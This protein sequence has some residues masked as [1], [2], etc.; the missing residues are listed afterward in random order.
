MQKGQPVAAPSPIAARGGNFRQINNAPNA[1]PEEHPDPSKLVEEYHQAAIN[2][3]EA[4]FDGV[5]CV[6]FL[7]DLFGRGQRLNSFF[8]FFRNFSSSA[9]R[10]RVFNK[11]ILGQDV[12]PP[13]RQVGRIPREPREI[14]RRIIGCHR[15]QHFPEMRLLVLTYV[16]CYADESLGC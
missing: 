2:A 11:S 12:E 1:K 7:V 15:T 6:S 4:G 3:K 16:L 14:L 9:L 10:E 8:L 5:E 13:Y